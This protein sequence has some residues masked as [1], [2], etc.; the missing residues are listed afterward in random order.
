MGLF[1]I[2]AKTINTRYRILCISVL[3]Y[4]MKPVIVREN[5]VITIPKP[6][7]DELGIKEY[8]VLDVRVENGRIVLTKRK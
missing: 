7:R 5:G 3:V 8:S 4:L 6:V 2:W 1:F